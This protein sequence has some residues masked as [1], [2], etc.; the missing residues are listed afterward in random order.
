MA[1]GPGGGGVGGRGS[2]CK[3]S[4][5]GSRTTRGRD[6]FQTTWSSYAAVP[7]M[8]NI[9]MKTSTWPPMPLLSGPHLPGLCVR[10]H[11]GAARLDFGP[12]SWCEG[13]P[14][15][16]RAQRCGKALPGKS[17]QRIKKFDEILLLLLME[18]KSEEDNTSEQPPEDTTLIFALTP[19]CRR[20][21]SS[22]RRGSVSS[23][24][25]DT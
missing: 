9:I 1:F 19:L 16:H 23:Q 15:T 24:S 5:A 17:G 2:T 13:D 3:K 12:R 8:V 18:G 22:G 10:R 4:E 25:R 14:S 6:L 7:S 20:P 21:F 11:P